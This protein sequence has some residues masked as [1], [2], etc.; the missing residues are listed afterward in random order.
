MLDGDVTDV[1]EAKSLGIR[2]GYV[3]IYSASWGPDDDGKTVDGPG[4]LAKQ[5]FEYGVKKVRGPGLRRVPGRGG[6]AVTPARASEGA[7]KSLLFS[8]QSKGV[9]QG[10][11]EVAVHQCHRQLSSASGRS[12]AS[13]VTLP[14]SLSVPAGGGAVLA[15]HPA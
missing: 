9:A 4:H 12:S 11:G 14:W 8:D 7:G 10:L 15:G 13:P 3:D 1:V 6:Q 5:A 2:P